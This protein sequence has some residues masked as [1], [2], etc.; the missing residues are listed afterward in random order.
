MDQDGWRDSWAGVTGVLGR[1]SE[2]VQACRLQRESAV[3]TRQ[4]AAD[5]RLASCA[6]RQSITHPA[7]THPDAHDH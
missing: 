2:L 7:I 6:M 3:T 4:R 1:S 5:L